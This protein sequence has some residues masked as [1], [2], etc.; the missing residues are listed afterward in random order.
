[1][2]FTVDRPVADTVGPCPANEADARPAACD[3]GRRQLLH[4]HAASVGRRLP[5]HRLVR[6]IMNIFSRKQE[7]KVDRVIREF[8]NKI[9]TA[10]GLARV[11][12]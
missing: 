6:L 12:R 11:Q 7:T 2:R 9:P 1:M 10:L 5:R 4:H 3:D 8:I